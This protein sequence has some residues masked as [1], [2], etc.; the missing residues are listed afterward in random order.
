MDYLLSLV[1]KDEETILD[2]MKEMVENVDKVKNREKEIDE[3]NNKLED[4]TEE[5]YYLRNK[6][7][8]KR[9]VIEEMENESEKID[10]KYKKAKDDLKFKDKE[11]NLLEKLIGEQVEEI[12]ILRENNQS[13]VIQIS[14]NVMMENKINIQN[15]VIKELKDKMKEESKF[16]NQNEE[17][18]KLDEEI[19]YLKDVNEEKEIQLK[20]ISEENDLLIV[21]LASLEAIESGNIILKDKL[22]KNEDVEKNCE[23]ESHFGRNFA[24][25]ECCKTFGS[26]VDLKTHKRIVHAMHIMKMRLHEL[27]I[28]ILEQKLDVS[29]KRSR[30]YLSLCWLVCN[31]SP[32]A[33][34]GKVFQHK[35]LFKISEDYR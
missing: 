29:V 26:R 34:M 18:V 20:N 10:E 13:M 15:K 21:K 30:T 22:D 2:A 35:S 25:K 16:I 23:L 11:R 31:Q 12:N 3:L 33:F 5:I 14:E 32:E 24:C 1:G 4:H 7:D 27:D 19:Q 17:I 8:Q 28:R 6:L 9:N